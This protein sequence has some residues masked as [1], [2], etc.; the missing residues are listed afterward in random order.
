MNSGYEA[1]AA[2]LGTLVKYS[3][4]MDECYLGPEEFSADPRHSLVMKY[5]RH[6]W[7]QDGAIDPMLMIKHSGEKIE[8]IGGLS[9]LIELTKWCF[10]PANFDK[11]QRSVRNAYIAKKMSDVAIGIAE[12]GAADGADGAKLLF[13]AKAAMD[14]ISELTVKDKGQGLKHV[15]HLMEGHADKIIERKKQ[16]GIT[17]TKT[18]SRK[19]DRLIGGHQKGD[20]DIYAARPSMGKTAL[21]INEMIAAARGGT[22]VAF[23]SLEMTGA[24][25]IDRFLCALANIE[26]AKMRTG[27][28]DDSDWERYSF[29]VDEFLKLPIYVD[30]TSG[31]KLQ[32]IRK[33]TKTL[34]KERGEVVVYIDY[35]QLVNPGKTFKEPRDGVK[36]VS[37]GLKLMART[38]EVPVVAISAVG[39]DCEKRVDKRPMMSDLRDSGSIE[40]DAD[41]LVFL[42]RDEYYNADTDDKGIVELIVPK[43]RNVGVG[44]VKMA[45]L[46]QYGKFSDIDHAKG[47]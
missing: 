11:Y 44:K 6:C 12:A 28:F 22:T 4:Y 2:V 15:A 30:D 45:F 29:A 19:L 20:L 47:A 34:I 27:D 39:R 23:F 18:V 43:G 10:T 40:S 5:I 7:E 46:K 38:L 33:E 24:L 36:H 9:Y 25:I 16:R 37:G 8:R 13:E 14:E 17:G 21:I 1:E 35:L 31:I 41:V 3:E 26:N 42:Y 32:D